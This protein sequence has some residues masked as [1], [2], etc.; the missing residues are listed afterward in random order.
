[1]RI[2]YFVGCGS[3]GIPAYIRNMI[4]RGE[5]LKYLLLE[6]FR[7]R[8]FRVE[9]LCSIALRLRNNRF[10]MLQCDAD[11][12]QRPMRERIRVV[13][14]S[15]KTWHIVM[16]NQHRHAVRIVKQCCRES[17]I[18]S[19]KIEKDK[20]HNHELLVEHQSRIASQVLVKWN[21]IISR[22]KR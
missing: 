4:H 16:K 5:A 2:P 8:V 22:I 11:F 7:K 13:N 3:Q 9:I 6:Y 12:S 21:E 1:M 17:L 19:N 10:S 18:L 20:I 15:A 14:S